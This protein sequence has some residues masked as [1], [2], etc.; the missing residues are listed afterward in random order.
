MALIDKK[1]YLGSNIL[2]TLSDVN[3]S[4]SNAWI[5]T[6]KLTRIW[7]SDLFDKMKRYF[8]QTV[9]VSLLLNA[10]TKDFNETLGEKS[11]VLFA[12]HR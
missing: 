4:K 10:C 6:D 12:I 5:A 2:S 11:W 7:K 9:A 8:F 3:I 1:T